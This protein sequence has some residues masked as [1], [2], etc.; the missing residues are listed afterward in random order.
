M[1]FSGHPS[2]VEPL[3][4]E[5]V[6]AQSFE[7]VWRSVR[8]LGIPQA[9]VDDVAQD[10]FVIVHRKLDSLSSA[11]ALRSW[12]FGI[13]RRVCRDHQRST[14]RRGQHLELD[15]ER[16]CAYGHDPQERI[17]SR[18]ALGRVKAYAESLDDERRALFFL[19]LVEG[20]SITETAE[21]LG[22]NANTTYSRVRVLRR[23]LGDV[24]GGASAE[25]ERGKD[26]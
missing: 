5:R 22:M 2:S 25:M 8:G 10:V 20:L 24:L 1:A 4:F 19:A 12:L 14:A 23:Q 6:Y 16:E 15:A 7:F 13:V 11:A 26:D 21:A 18:Q 3:E 9:A 17:A